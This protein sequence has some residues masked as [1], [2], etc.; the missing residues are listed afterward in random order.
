[1][2]IVPFQVRCQAYNKLFLLHSGML[3]DTFSVPDFFF[4]LL[5]SKS[6]I[7]SAHYLF[8]LSQ[9]SILLFELHVPQSCIFYKS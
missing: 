3:L 2:L 4:A 6:A 5:A 7:R 1:M 8:H 9:R